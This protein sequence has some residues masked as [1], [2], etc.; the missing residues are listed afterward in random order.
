MD[1]DS[2]D[3][4]WPSLVDYLPFIGAVYR[5]Y[6]WRVAAAEEGRR[7]RAAGRREL[8]RA[9]VPLSASAAAALLAAGGVDSAGYA[10]LAALT[11]LLLYRAVELTSTGSRR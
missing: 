2:R 5:F 9:T 8:R 1:V 10:V 6:W 3:W 4:G 7:W 11:G